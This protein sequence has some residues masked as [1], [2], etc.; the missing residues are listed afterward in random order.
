MKKASIVILGFIVFVA[1]NNPNPGESGVVNDGIQA[2]DSNGAF[3][4][5]TR[6]NPNSNVDSSVGDDRVDTEK[7][8]SANR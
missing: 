2:V 5:T 4:D 3:S 1:C 7:R 6:L 8:D